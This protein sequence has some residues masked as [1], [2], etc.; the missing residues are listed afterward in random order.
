MRFLLVVV[1]VL[2]LA[3][4]ANAGPEV[5]GAWVTSWS[6]GMFTPQQI[7]NTIAAMKKAG[8]NALF[9]EVRKCADAYY[10]SK[11]EPKGKEVPEGFDPLAYAIEKCH[12]Q[13]IQVHAW[14]VVYRAYSGAKT[15]PTDPNHIVRKR[16]DWVML[17][18][19]GKNYSGEGM[20]L[21]PGVPEVREYLVSIFE[22]IAKRYNIDG[23]QYDYVRYPSKSWGYSEAA[24][25]HYYAD[26]G[27]KSKPAP[28]DPRWCQWR[29]DQVTRLVRMTHQRV[30]AVNPKCQISASTICYGG[31]PSRWE[32][33]TPYAGVFQDW[34]LWM[35]EG[36]IDI[37]I[38]MNYKSEKSA[39]QAK[40]FRDWIKLSEDWNG[41][42]PVY[43]GLYSD[44]NQA[45]DTLKQ[46]EATRKV[47]QEGFVLFSFNQN[48]RRDALAAAL[49]A[50]LGA[51]P[52]LR[53]NAP[54]VDLPVA[55]TSTE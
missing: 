50:K 36:Y 37:N 20:Y 13:G 46:I 30:K 48:S 38:P 42:R 40:V 18:D 52:K 14:V 45:S 24:L 33:S 22:D 2:A 28:N 55:K 4:A 53:V 6:P 23:L 16:P 54:A 15:G 51:A 29:R 31:T 11:I 17:S 41:G 47:G 7:D 32:Q 27:T 44:Q 49:G 12:P 19:T 26:T 3:A 34:Y 21:D 9:M 43:Q 35:R 25:K 39:R 8:L 1:L 10:D 5:R